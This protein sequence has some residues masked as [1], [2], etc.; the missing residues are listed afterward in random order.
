MPLEGEYGASPTGWVR[1]QVE[2]YESTNGAEGNTLRDTGLPIIIMGTRGAKSGMVRKIPLMRVEHEG[3]YAIVG[4]KGGAPDHPL[5]YYNLLAHPDEVTIQ[6]GPEPWDADIREIDGAERDEWWERC[7]AAFPPYADYKAKTD[8]VI[9]VFIA[10][11][12]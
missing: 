4:S 9:P 8:R 7:V 12:R 5:W 10:T 6:D 2:L 3:A 1:D 11:P